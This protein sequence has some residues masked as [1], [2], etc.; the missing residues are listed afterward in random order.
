MSG[1]SVFGAHRYEPGAK[2]TGE[3]ESES[4]S[5]SSESDGEPQRVVVFTGP[6]GVG[7]STLIKRLC[8]QHPTV[9]ELSVSQTSRSPRTGEQN[10]VD[11]HFVTKA[12]IERARANAELIEWAEVHGQLYATPY[13]EV[14]RIAEKLGA[15]GVPVLDLDPT[16]ARTLHWW[17][18]KRLAP[19]FLFVRPPSLD[20]LAARLKKRGTESDDELRRRFAASEEVLEAVAD[21][22]W[23]AV[24]TNDSLEHCYA[25]LVAVLRQYGALPSSSPP[26]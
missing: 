13:R 17:W 5:S 21:E 2:E 19:I 1:E 4:D 18:R 3:D 23:T 16:G 12:E 7:K 24:L 25:H 11:Y 22:H 6:S 9:F 8:A 14:K 15:R 20:E 26:H 10:G